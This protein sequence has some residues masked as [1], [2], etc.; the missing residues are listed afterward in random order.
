MK[1]RAVTMAQTMASW[2]Y[3]VYGLDVKKYLGSFTSDNVK[4]KETDV[5]ADYRRL[6]QWM[7][8]GKEEKIMLVGWSQGAGMNLLAGTPADNKKIFTGMICIGLTPE[9]VLGWKFSDE[10]ADA[11]KKMP[12][13]PKFRSED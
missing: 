1:R 10:F 5:M 7:A 11:F 9:C 8:N 2:G 13:E 4:L 12:N 6:A 3:E